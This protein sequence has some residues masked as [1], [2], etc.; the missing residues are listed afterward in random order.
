MDFILEH[1]EDPI[2]D[3]TSVAAATSSTQPQSGPM[4]EDDDEE[5]AALRAVYGVNPGAAALDDSGVEARVSGWDYFQKLLLLINDGRFYRASNAQSA[6]RYSRTRHSLTSTP[7]RADTIS[8]KSLPRRCVRVPPLRCDVLTFYGVLQ[9]KPLTEEEKQQKLLEL[10]DKMNEK[11]AKKAEEEAKE[12]KANELIRRK[13]G[14]VRAGTRP[15]ATNSSRVSRRR[16][17]RR[18]RRSKKI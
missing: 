4:D 17:N 12:A 6:G 16:F 2:P 7:R 14:K 1:N 5:T 3:P 18:P 9:I 13:A 10:R 8:S 15:Q 11:R